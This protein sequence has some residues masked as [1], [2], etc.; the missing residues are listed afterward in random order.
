MHIPV[1]SRRIQVAFTT[2]AF[3]ALAL[4]PVA[5]TSAVFEGLTVQKS[6]NPSTA[7]GSPYIC[8][9]QITNST[10]T[11]NTLQLD[12]ISDVAHA[13]PSAYNRRRRLG[14]PPVLAAA[15]LHRRHTGLHRRQWPR[16]DR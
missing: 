7:V 6:C 11:H 14:R 10:G 4:G 13:L 12:G 2:I 15:R 3:L 1:P 8:A 16:H 5:T 9:Y